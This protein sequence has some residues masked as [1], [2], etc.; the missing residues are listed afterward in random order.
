MSRIPSV[1][2]AGQVA[3]VTGARR[4]I[5]AETALVLA[6]A[7]ADVVVSDLVTEKGELDAV[8]QEIRGLGRKALAIKADVREREQVEAMVKK[9]VEAFG[10]IDILV[11]NAGIGMPEGPHEPEKFEERQKMIQQRMAEFMNAKTMLNHYDETRYEKIL[12]TNLRSILVC[13]RAVADV[14]INQ[15]YGNIVNL[16]SVQAYDRGAPAWGAYSISKR[17]ILMITEALAVDLARYNIR[18]NAIAPGG[19]VT[20]M[21]R[22]IIARPEMKQMLENRMLLG[23]KLIGP[24]TCGHLILFLVS[25]LAKYIT[26]QTITIDAGLTLARG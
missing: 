25:D 5:G 14:M 4:G 3:V 8:A 22:D 24:E 9:T 1:S 13:S 21:M 11:N 12:E 19:I 16:S 23:G 26:G 10:R 17:G 7:G 6:E 2:L 15:K 20:E 18:V